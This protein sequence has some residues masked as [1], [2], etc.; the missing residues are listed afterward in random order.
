MLA[1]WAHQPA[2]TC[3]NQPAPTRSTPTTRRFSTIASRRK[4]LPTLLCRWVGGRSAGMGSC[5]HRRRHPTLLC[6]LLVAIRTR[7]YRAVVGPPTNH[8]HLDP[9][10]TPQHT[11]DQAHPPPCA[12]P[13][14]PNTPLSNELDTLLKVL[15]GTLGF[16][17]PWVWGAGEALLV[18]WVGGP[19]GAE[20]FTDLAGDWARNT[21]A[22]FQGA[23][24]P[25]QPKQALLGDSQPPQAPTL[26]GAAPCNLAG[27]VP[28]G[29]VGGGG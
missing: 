3:T 18:P 10:P 23:H 11:C 15:P 27:A 29:G 8:P 20:A 5:P 6:V 28:V 7:S 4:P 19:L 21:T 24:P 25:H 16:A 13:M 17:R 22:W 26:A 9:P 14:V 1:S 12:T 2:P